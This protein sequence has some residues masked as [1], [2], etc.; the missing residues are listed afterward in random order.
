MLSPAVDTHCGV[1]RDS[2]FVAVHQLM[3][4]TARTFAIIRA[5]GRLLALWLLIDCIEFAVVLLHSV[6]VLQTDSSPESWIGYGSFS[7]LKFVIAAILFGAS[8][9]FV[10]TLLLI[11]VGSADDGFH[12]PPSQ[13][14][15]EVFRNGVRTL[16]TAAFS[17]AG[18]V[19]LLH[20]GPQLLSLLASKHFDLVYAVESADGRLAEALA[21][22]VGGTLFILTPRRWPRL[23]NWFMRTPTTSAGTRPRPRIV[24]GSTATKPDANETDSSIAPDDDPPS[25]VNDTAV[26]H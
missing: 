3:V 10:A 16:I 1:A 14:T 21:N 15:D 17:V 2:N 7:L 9:R 12:D 11:R 4:L 6:V 20:G 19:L 18:I 25:T 26:G 24:A 22:L 8:D 5:V 13:V 23:M